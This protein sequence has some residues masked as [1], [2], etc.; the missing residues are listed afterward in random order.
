MW[1]QCD[2]EKKNTEATEGN[3]TERRWVIWWEGLNCFVGFGDGGWVWPGGSGR[4]QKWEKSNKQILSWSSK[5]GSP[6]NTIILV[7]WDPHGT[8]N[9]QKYKVINLCFLRPYI[10]G[11]L[12]GQKSNTHGFQLTYNRLHLISIDFIFNVNGQPRTTFEKCF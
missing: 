6:T 3:V 4:L 5:K 1:A 2:L 10:F 12:L 9:L 7:Q 11:N 8:S